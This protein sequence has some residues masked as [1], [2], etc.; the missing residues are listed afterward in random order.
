MCQNLYLIY[1]SVFYNLSVY[2]LFGH[3]ILRK[4]LHDGLVI[5]SHVA[6]DMSA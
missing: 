2:G 1:S 3:N 6:V 4:H 5:M